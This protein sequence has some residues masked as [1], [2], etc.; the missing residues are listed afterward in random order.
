[1]RLNG[2]TIFAPRLISL[3]LLLTIPMNAFA[4]YV[5]AMPDYVDIYNH[6]SDGNPSEETYAPEPLE[7]Y[8]PANSG[9]VVH[10]V[11]H[12]IWGNVSNT[13]VTNNGIANTNSRNPENSMCAQ[14]P[15]RA[16]HVPSFRPSSIEDK[17]LT[18]EQQKALVT[19]Q[20][21]NKYGIES[22]VAERRDPEFLKLSDCSG[23]YQKKQCFGLLKRA[24]TDPFQ[25]SSKTDSKYQELDISKSW[26]EFKEAIIK[27]PGFEKDQAIVDSL[28]VKKGP[29]QNLVTSPIADD[30]ARLQVSTEAFGMIDYQLAIGNGEEAKKILDRLQIINPSAASAV[31]CLMESED[32]AGSGHD[33]FH[34]DPTKDKVGPI[35]GTVFYKYDADQEIGILPLI[36]AGGAAAGGGAAGGAAV[37]GGATV[38]TLG[39]VGLSKVLTGLGIAAG[40][41]LISESYDGYVK[42]P[43]GIYVPHGTFTPPPTSTPPPSKEP[44]DPGTKSV[45]ITAVAAPIV[46]LIKWVKEAVSEKPSETPKEAPVVP[47]VPA[48]HGSP[49]NGNPHP[50]EPELVPLGVKEEEEPDSAPVIET[51]AEF[52]AWKKHYAELEA[53]LKAEQLA[54]ELSIYHFADDPHGGIEMASNADCEL[55]DEQRDELTKTYTE[56]VIL[57]TILETQPIDFSDSSWNN[58]SPEMQQECS[59]TDPVD[60]IY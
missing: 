38:A 27:N 8:P 31:T 10:P 32:W 21:M 6:T 52:E 24:L 9:P 57:Q 35:S 26:V 25:A 42:T 2:H 28:N 33:P 45:I 51:D 22:V 54:Q 59:V 5:E 3:A 23:G 36:I 17:Y 44:M 15:S 53:K 30:N 16:G 56:N 47:S 4:Q 20:L 37:G 7:N 40:A 60:P 58:L 41:V 1:M 14:F 29:M 11:E 43:G 13:T 19:K 55:S 50:V 48:N 39:G 18:A 34:S 49:G 12:I 46:E